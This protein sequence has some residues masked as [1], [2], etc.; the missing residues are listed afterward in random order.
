MK[1]WSV[2]MSRKSDY[3]VSGRGMLPAR[4]WPE[5]LPLKSRMLFLIIW[6]QNIWSV[7]W[8][9]AALFRLM[10][11]LSNHWI[12]IWIKGL[13][14]RSHLRSGQLLNCRPI[15]WITRSSKRKLRLKK[16]R[17]RKSWK[18]SRKMPLNICRLM[19]GQW[20]LMIMWWLRFRVRIWKLKNL[21]QLKRWLFWPVI[22]KMN[23]SSTRLCLV[24]GRGKKRPLRW[25]TRMII[26][27]KSL[28]VK[29]LNI[30]SRW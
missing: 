18:N 15:I 9:R 1:R 10:Y 6:Y 13:N 30:I 28:P 11:Q 26:L 23:L 29:T 14:F 21:C 19:T 12:L 8:K 16:K 5:C 7:N 22:P 25:L 4:W 24:C 3:Q 17:W 2:I 20:L 27:R